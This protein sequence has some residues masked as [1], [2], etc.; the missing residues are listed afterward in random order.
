MC[1]ECIEQELN[2]PVN[3]GREI[4]LDFP[5]N[6]ITVDVGCVHML[7]YNARVV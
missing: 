6:K 5:R 4:L 3:I 2:M 1:T 7:I